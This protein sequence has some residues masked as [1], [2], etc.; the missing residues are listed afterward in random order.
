MLDGDISVGRPSEPCIE[1]AIRLL[2]SQPLELLDDRHEVSR[3]GAMM[4]SI[5]NERD[6]VV[7]ELYAFKQNPVAD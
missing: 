7:H 1:R 2:S 6:F 5:R 3:R 4:N